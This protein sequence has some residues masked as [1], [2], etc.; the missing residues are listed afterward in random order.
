[1]G[2]YILIF[3][4]NTLHKIL[5]SDFVQY[6]WEVPNFLFEE[7]NLLYNTNKRVPVEPLIEPLYIQIQFAHQIEVV[8]NYTKNIKNNPLLLGAKFSCNCIFAIT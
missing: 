2:Y 7:Y 5:K 6:P 4:S 3:F 1:M 8:I